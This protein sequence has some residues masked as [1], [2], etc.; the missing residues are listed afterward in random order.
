MIT[1]A[2]LSEIKKRSERYAKLLNNPTSEMTK[3]LS[4]IGLMCI[5]DIPLLIAEIET[6]NTDVILGKSINLVFFDEYA[7]IEPVLWENLIDPR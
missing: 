7:S 4:D 5:V 1:P 6:I 3:H 2:E